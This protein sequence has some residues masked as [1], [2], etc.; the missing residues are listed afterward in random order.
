MA[1]YLGQAKRGI[2][3][4]KPLPQPVSH[5]TDGDRLVFHVEH[6]PLSHPLQ[7]LMEDARQMHRISGNFAFRSVVIAG[8]TSAPAIPD[9]SK[10]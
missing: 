1:Q 2:F 3:S 7:Q 6:G 5:L 10:S 4:C 9:S 8:L